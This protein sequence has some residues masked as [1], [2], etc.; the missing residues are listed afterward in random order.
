MQKE[1]IVWIYNLYTSFGI[2]KVKQ[3]AD[4]AIDNTGKEHYFVRQFAASNGTIYGIDYGE[5]GDETTNALAILF[6]MS[7][8]TWDKISKDNTCGFLNSFAYTQGLC[9]GGYLSAKEAYYA[10][11][12]AWDIRNTKINGK[13][14]RGVY[15][16]STGEDE[17]VTEKLLNNVKDMSE[18]NNGE[19]GV[20]IEKDPIATLQH[21]NSK[22]KP[23][24]RFVSEMR[25][26]GVTT[27]NEA[28]QNFDFLVVYGFDLEH[29][30]DLRINE[31]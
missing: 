5:Y 9:N 22:N 2:H 7:K 16:I 14:N 10:A 18:I 3:E 25:Q 24:K 21:N 4:S 11:H 12:K 17:G 19:M 15:G 29:Q 13:L 8:S 6:T 27:K 31:S 28:L 30:N 20:I 26:A 23:L 1:N